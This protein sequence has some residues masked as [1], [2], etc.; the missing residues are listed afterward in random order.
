MVHSANIP[1]PSV[2]VARITACPALNAVIVPFSS[3][4]TIS[5]LLDVQT[6]S[7]LEASAGE[8]AGVNE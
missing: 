7:F 8:I 4:A 2:E 6:R 1:E 5:S 3:T